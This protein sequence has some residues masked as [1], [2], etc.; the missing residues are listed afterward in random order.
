[1]S[2]TLYEGSL[3]FLL[4]NPDGPT[5]LMLSRTAD[6]IAG[7]YEFLVET[8]FQN[9]TIRPTVDTAVEV[10]DL[11]LIASIGFPYEG[12]VSERLADK[13][14]ERETDHLLPVIMSAW[15]SQI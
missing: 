15:D 2:V 14:G 4:E 13:I 5:G 6:Q 7:N 1:M 11:G 8:I 12:N 3:Q 9:P 10:G